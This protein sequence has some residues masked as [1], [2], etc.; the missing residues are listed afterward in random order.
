M[1]SVVELSSS[2][3]IS[4]S[5][6]LFGTALFRVANKKPQRK[7]KKSTKNAAKEH[8][9]TKNVSNFQKIE[10]REHESSGGASSRETNS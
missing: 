10:K 8:H 5:V 4:L 7:E 9:D 6:I 3:L 1:F 2:L